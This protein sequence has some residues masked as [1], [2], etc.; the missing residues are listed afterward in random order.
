VFHHDSV[1]SVVRKTIITTSIGALAFPLTNLLFSSPA[2]Q[3]TM[4][5]GV[6]GV[7]LIIQFL[8]DFEKR[9]ERVE[10]RQVEHSADVREA[11]EEG[12]SK[13]SNVTRLLRDLE[14]GG[15]Q[16]D[17][18]LRLLE[19]A[20]EIGPNPQPLLSAFIY[21]EMGRISRFLH[22]IADQEATYDG[23]DRD[24]LLSLTSSA[25]ISIDAISLPTVDAGGENFDGGFWWSDL[26]H[27]YLALQR[28]AVQRGVPVRRIFVLE[29]TA[30]VN[31]PG[32]L[33]IFQ[34][35]TEAGIEVR[36]LHPD[37]MPPTMTRRLYD[38]ILFDD[39]LSYEV[40][41]A[42]RVDESANPLILNTR[43]VLDPSRVDDRKERFRQLWTAANPYPVPREDDIPVLTR[44][45]RAPT[46]YRGR[47]VGPA[48][49]TGV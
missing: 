28:E 26:G 27:R 20:V 17:S 8:I 1:H 32:L 19:K 38:F 42:T 5:A 35:Q 37:L 10:T 36:V 33:L 16:T 13:V 6:G 40:T 29:R 48:N 21:A 18:V 23:E 43:L 25:T 30:P 4:S 44:D 47:L 3:L 9:L 14:A 31:D 15:W 49:E 45:G 7:V 11:V 46:R 22:E 41:P 24:W 12:F 34:A 39:V 2:A